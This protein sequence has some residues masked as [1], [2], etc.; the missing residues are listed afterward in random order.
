M[1]LRVP[2]GTRASV[3]RN[4]TDKEVRMK[5]LVGVMGMTI[6]AVWGLNG[7][8]WSEQKDQGKDTEAEGFKMTCHLTGGVAPSVS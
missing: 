1:I 7:S 2:V 6:D 8:A 3:V 4:H 5:P